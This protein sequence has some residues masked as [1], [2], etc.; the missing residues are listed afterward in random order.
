M[1]LSSFSLQACLTPDASTS[2]CEMWIHASG[3]PCEAT[4]TG[5]QTHAQRCLPRRLLRL[6]PQAGCRDTPPACPRMS[7]RKPCLTARYKLQVWQGMFL[8]LARMH[9]WSFC[10]LSERHMVLDGLAAPAL[11]TAKCPQ[12]LVATVSSVPMTPEELVEAVR[13]NLIIREVLSSASVFP[14]AEA[15]AEGRAT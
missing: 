12:D 9:Q 10:R 13:A 11:P 1:L 4:I 14:R 7:P 5:L 6:M 15:S 8:F 3:K 2:L